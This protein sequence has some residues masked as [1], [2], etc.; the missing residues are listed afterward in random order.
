MFQKKQKWSGGY[1]WIEIKMTISSSGCIY[2]RSSCAKRWGMER[3]LVPY[4]THEYIY[5]ERRIR[6]LGSCNTSYR[7]QEQSDTLLKTRKKTWLL[8]LL[9]MVVVHNTFPLARQSYLALLA[10]LLPGKK[11]WMY[12]LAEWIWR[13][14]WE[15]RKWESSQKKRRTREEIG[16]FFSR[17]SLS[18][19]NLLP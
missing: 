1:C 2:R 4:C 8:L 17:L 10:H 16:F 5:F 14:E 15:K 12:E 13:R 3:V 11:C 6:G 18:P 19:R 7:T 9:L